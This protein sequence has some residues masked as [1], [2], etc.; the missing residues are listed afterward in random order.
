MGRLCCLLGLPPWLWALFHIHSCWISNCKVRWFFLCHKRNQELWNKHSGKSHAQCPEFERWQIGNKRFCNAR[1]NS[2]F[3]LFVLLLRGSHLTKFPP[4]KG[5]GWHNFVALC[6]D[7]NSMS[8]LPN[9]HALSMLCPCI[10]AS[11]HVRQNCQS[12]ASNCQFIAGIRL[13]GGG[14][15]VVA[16]TRWVGN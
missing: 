2:A 13:W 3:E 15:L 5:E 4:D 12:R 16:Y 1:I 8:T 11:K 14:Q 7:A 9:A 10:V 6:I